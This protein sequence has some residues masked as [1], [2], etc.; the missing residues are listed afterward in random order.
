MFEKNIFLVFQ[1]IGLIMRRQALSDYAWSI[2][3]RW[4]SNQ[5]YISIES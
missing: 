2:F 1:N 5:C 4:D 3:E